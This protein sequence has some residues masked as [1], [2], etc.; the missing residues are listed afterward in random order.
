MNYMD[1]NMKIN[2]AIAINQF[3][4]VVKMC[5]VSSIA[6]GLWR[7]RMMSCMD[8]LAFMAQPQIIQCAPIIPIIY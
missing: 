6:F 8:V 3:S 2:K 4:L 7:R 5:R 1:P